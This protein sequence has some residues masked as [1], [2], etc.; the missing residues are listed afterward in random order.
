MP[1]RVEGWGGGGGGWRCAWEG[2]AVAGEGGGVLERVE[3][4]G[5]GG[6]GWRCA[7]EGGAV[8]GEGGGVPGRVGRWRGRVEV[9]WDQGRVEL[10]G[11]VE[12]WWSG[13]SLGRVDI[14]KC[15]GWYSTLVAP[16]QMMSR[17]GGTTCSVS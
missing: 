6:G 5:G 7:G 14:C 12:W 9:G 8:A 15:M 1:E 4:W 16:R 11:N 3:G 17:F 13:V 2:G 10:C